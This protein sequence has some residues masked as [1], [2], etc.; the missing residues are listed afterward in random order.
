MLATFYS[1]EF[2][3]AVQALLFFLNSADRAQAAARENPAQKDQTGQFNLNLRQYRAS[4]QN[5]GM[6]ELQIQRLID[7]REFTD[8]VEVIAPASGFILTRKVSDGLRFSKGDEL[9]RIVDLSR[10][11]ILVDV[12]ENQDTYFQPGALVTVNRPGRE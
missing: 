8:K 5:L 4:L 10:V 2:L 11:W 7:T 12:F 9:Y 6:G 1:P 3:S